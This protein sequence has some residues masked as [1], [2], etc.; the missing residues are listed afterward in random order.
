MYLK[1][2]LGHINAL[3]KNV[4]VWVEAPYEFKEAKKEILPHASL[5]L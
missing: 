1:V 2:A 3:E 4:G 5:I